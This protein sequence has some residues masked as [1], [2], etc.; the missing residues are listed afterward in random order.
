MQECWNTGRYPVK[1]G[2]IMSFRAYRTREQDCDLAD[3]E[4]EAR[5]HVKARSLVTLGNCDTETV[6]PLQE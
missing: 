1:L 4:Y 5:T 3:L 2:E 6:F